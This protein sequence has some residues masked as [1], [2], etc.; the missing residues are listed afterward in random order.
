M[1]R[2]L[3]HFLPG[4]TG[5]LLSYL[6][7]NKQH[8]L[9]HLI[10]KDDW[11]SK[12]CVSIH[13]G[14]DSVSGT[15]RVASPQGLSPIPFHFFNTEPWHCLTDEMSK[16]QEDVENTG[17][18]QER[19]GRNARLFSPFKGRRRPQYSLMDVTISCL[20]TD[21]TWQKTS[22]LMA[23]FLMWPIWKRAHVFHKSQKPSANVNYKNL[24]KN[25]RNVQTLFM[26][27]LKPFNPAQYISSKSCGSFPR[28]LESL[29]TLSSLICQSWEEKSDSIFCQYIIN[30]LWCHQGHWCK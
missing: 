15:Q 16:T 8:L 30:P 2:N 21:I 17:L 28:N 23:P 12:S 26:S 5:V 22:V 4:D 27:Q 18:E 29:K 10:L 14:G 20:C 9:G 25:Y 1:A 24:L 13:C 6:Q 3:I 19:S 11:R 7:R